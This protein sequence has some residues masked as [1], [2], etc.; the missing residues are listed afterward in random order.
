MTWC[1]VQIGTS[2]EGRA[3]TAW[4]SPATAAP[5]RVLVVSGQHG[6]E[7]RAVRAVERLLREAPA[8]L[9]CQVA[10]IPVLNPDGLARRSRTNAAGIDLNRDHLL[11][12]A[13]ETHA[14]HTFIRTWQPDVIVDVHNYP[15]R[16]RELL[17]A[18]VMLSWHVCVDVA[19]H[20]AAVADAS[21]VD[22]V[23]AALDARG[24]RWSR[25]LLVRPARLTRHSSPRPNDLRNAAALRHQ[26]P[27]V[28]LEGRA[29][30]WHDDRAERARLRVALDLALRVT[31]AWAADRPSTPRPIAPHPGLRVPVGWRWLEARPAQLDVWNLATASQGEL[32]VAR[33]TAGLRPRRHVVLPDAYAVPTAARRLRDLLTR[34]GFHG[35]ERRDQR[36]SWLVLPVAQP[37]GQTLA[38]LF[39]GRSRDRLARRPDL[40]PE[41]EGVEPLAMPPR[42]LS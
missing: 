9:P 27:T 17:A 3:L 39:E 5:R 24:L 32:R 29:P 20:P 42:R 26:V 18:G 11:L 31:I 14:L 7:R 35:T 34:H 38:V 10:A 40:R 36:D 22:R 21:I 8:G 25:Y 4:I 30:T 16:R 41:C 19:T 37:G 6:D 13:P 15:S 33:F 12:V 1:A 2:G 23:G 28:L